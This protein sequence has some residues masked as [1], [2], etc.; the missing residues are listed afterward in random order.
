MN[1]WKTRELSL[2][3]LNGKLKERKGYLEALFLTLDQCVEICEKHSDV[4]YLNICG[5]TTLKAKNYA[6]SSYSLILDGHG[7]EAGACSRPFLEYMELLTYFREDPS[8]IK[9]VAQDNLPSAGA[10]AKKIESD[11]QGY[12]EYLNKHASHS[13]F[14]EYSLKHLFEEGKLRLS[15]PFVLKTLETNIRD[16]YVQVWLLACEAVNAIQTYKMGMAEG[17]AFALQVHQ[18]E[19]PRVFRLHDLRTN[20]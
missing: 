10:R 4:E 12:R 14:S 3:A 20:T 11:Y 17:Q 1:I 5:L 15:Q 13:S 6:L 19:A 7:Q 8:R 18:K 2:D 9:Q 16:L